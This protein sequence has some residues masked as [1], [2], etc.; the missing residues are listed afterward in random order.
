MSTLKNYFRVS[1]FAITV[2]LF[3][4]FYFFASYLHTSMLQEEYR[5]TSAALSQQVFSS[6]YQVMRKGWSRSDLETFLGSIE[7]SFENTGLSV[8]IYRGQKVEA[9]FGAIEQ[10]PFSDAVAEVFK[11]AKKHEIMYDNTIATITPIV[12][13]AECLNCHANAKAG[14]VLGAVEVT[15]TY[16]DMLEDVWYK[17]FVFSLLLFPVIL[18]IIYVISKNLLDKI[19]GSMESFR[20]QIRDINSVK[21]FKNFDIA[22]VP[23]SFREFDD[24]IKELNVLT[25]KLKDIAVDKDILEFEVKL[26]DK[27]I[28]TSEI[29]QDW[30]QYIKELLKEINTIMP[31]YSLIT[32]FQTDEEYCE[33]EIFWLGKPSDICREYMEE[34]AKKMIAEHAHFDALNFSV[35]H[36]ICD[37]Q[38]CLISLAIEDIDHESKSLILDTPKI[39][40]IVGLGIQ[41][42]LS[43][44]TIYAIV[45]DSILT[46]LINLVGSIKAIHKYTEN[47]EYYATR[48]PLTGLFNQ[49]VF[50]DLLE[51]EIKRAGRHGYHFGLLVID[52]DNFKMINDKYGH[53]FGDSFLQKLADL[54][55][56]CKRDEDILARYGGDEFTIVLPESTQEESYAVAERILEQVH[57]FTLEAP[58]GTPIHLTVSIGIATFPEHAT[59]SDTLFNVADAMM[60]RA[61][62]EGKDGSRF[63]SEYDLEEIHRESQNKA[64]MVLEAIRNKR[65]VPHFQ[66]IMRLKDRSVGIYELLMRIEID[67][68]I[69]NAQHFIET[70]ESLGVIHQMDYLVIEAAF[71]Q[72]RENGYDGLLFINLSPK[73]LIINEFIGKINTLAHTYGIDKSKIVFEITERET[74]KSFS[75]LEKFVFNLKLEGYRFAIDDF[76]SGF[77]SFHYIKKF[78]IDYIKID[79]DFILNIDSDRKDLAFVKSIVSLAKEL[80]VETVAEY[81]ENEKIQEFL[82]AIEIDYVQ[83]YHIGRPVPQLGPRG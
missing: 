31:V 42:Q 78:P 79:G 60:Y 75:L 17:H 76:G 81:V 8:A 20:K 43:K 10:P 51:Y 52:C 13:K 11:S 34:M 21:D 1:V 59:E 30:K 56:K 57:G 27:L 23:G 65:I 55:E 64:Y 70:A 77:S 71:M 47:L 32:I 54:L 45:I 49:R 36:N 16:G 3:T 74:I 61:K 9:L 14:D 6:M 46:T 80:E 63:P 25:H 69:Y 28:I 58:D 83:G 29:V 7:S 19:D 48:D 5:K 40:G 82:E 2:V 73:A 15:Y 66:P 37:E 18:L 68:K 53:S 62:N 39:G 35:R 33:I 4:V 26:L 72:I 38:T 22:A 24:V 50:R 41:S 12:A 67:D 44:D